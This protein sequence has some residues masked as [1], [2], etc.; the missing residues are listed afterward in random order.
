MPTADSFGKQQ[1]QLT[2]SLKVYQQLEITTRGHG[3]NIGHL[4]HEE[5]YYTHNR[6]K[7]IK[8]ADRTEMN[9][10]YFPKFS[11]RPTAWMRSTVQ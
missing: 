8:N 3:N 7:Q 10:T 4:F 1:K 11:L 5:N 2:S 9:T 6:N